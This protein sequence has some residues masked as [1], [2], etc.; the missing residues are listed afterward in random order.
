MDVD[1]GAVPADFDPR[2]V[3]PSRKEAL[4]AEP[5]QGKLFPREGPRHAMVGLEPAVQDDLQEL[6]LDDG[7][8]LGGKSAPFIA[9]H[10]G[11]RRG[12]GIGGWPHGLFLGCGRS[13]VRMV[14]LVMSKY[15]MRGM[16]NFRVNPVS[17]LK[18]TGEA[19]PSFS[20]RAR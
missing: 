5:A 12:P 10:P 3:V 6:F 15:S 2:H 4:G 16:I 1:L 8:L 19:L 14:S 13:P 11:L 7:N 18:L 20:R 17:S 9:I